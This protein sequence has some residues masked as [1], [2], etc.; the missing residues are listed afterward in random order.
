MH[1]S[2]S[3]VPGEGR[4]PWRRHGKGEG[5]SREPCGSGFLPYPSPSPRLRRGSPPSPG[6][7]EGVYRA[8]HVRPPSAGGL[9]ISSVSCGWMM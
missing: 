5:W 1:I 8:Y 4:G 9:M 7:G 6:A 2:P 3:P